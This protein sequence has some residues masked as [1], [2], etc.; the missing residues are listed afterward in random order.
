[1]AMAFAFDGVSLLAGQAGF[2]PGSRLTFLCFA[3]EK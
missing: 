2:R 1:M 3:K